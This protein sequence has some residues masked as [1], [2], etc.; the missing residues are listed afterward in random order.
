MTEYAS[1]CENIRI[2]QPKNMLTNGKKAYLTAKT[3][4]RERKVNKII[5]GYEHQI[6]TTKELR[7]AEGEG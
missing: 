3:Y 5:K 7:K 6:Q 2:K 4:I 1:D